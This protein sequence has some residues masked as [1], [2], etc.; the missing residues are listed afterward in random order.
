VQTATTSSAT[1]FKGGVSRRN[2]VRRIES[3]GCLHGFGA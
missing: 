2:A 3:C 1:I